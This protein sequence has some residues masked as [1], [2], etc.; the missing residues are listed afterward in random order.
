MVFIV[1]GFL[2]LFALA[3]SLLKGPQVRPLGIICVLPGVYQFSVVNNSAGLSSHQGNGVALYA[4]RARYRSVDFFNRALTF[5]TVL[6]V[7]TLPAT[8][9]HDVFKAIGFCKSFIAQDAYY[10]PLSLI[11]TFGILNLERWNVKL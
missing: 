6:S 8:G 2:L 4:K 11:N 3:F 5:L 1:V 10:S 7:R 9:D